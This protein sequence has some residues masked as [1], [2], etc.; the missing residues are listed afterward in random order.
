MNEI[1]HL[2]TVADTYIEAASVKEVTLSHRLFGDS[3]KL[4]ALRDGADITV[5]RFNGAMIWFSANWPDGAEWPEG[6]G[7]PITP[8]ILDAILLPTSERE[9]AA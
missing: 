6:I 7:R 2:L 1:A 8:E 5:S 4:T 3:K 9:D